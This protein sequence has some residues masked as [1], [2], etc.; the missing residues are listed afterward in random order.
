MVVE[1]G[2]QLLPQ[3][4]Q[5]V[6]HCHQLSFSKAQVIYN[7]HGFKTLTLLS[8]SA[9]LQATPSSFSNEDLGFHWLTRVFDQSYQSK[10]RAWMA[11]TMGRWP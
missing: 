10:G 8:T 4:V 11:T 7:R 2:S 6:P 3:S 5:M 9:I 1:I